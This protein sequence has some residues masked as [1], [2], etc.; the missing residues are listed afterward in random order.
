MIETT[1]SR[2][3]LTTLA[4]LAATVAEHADDYGDLLGIIRIV[5]QAA[6]QARRAVVA[7]ARA[8][9]VTWQELGDAL[10]TTR[11]AAQM[12]YGRS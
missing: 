4:T 11:Q 2:P 1:T 6:E 3:A 8:A 12:R 9:G 7:E 10:G 5:E